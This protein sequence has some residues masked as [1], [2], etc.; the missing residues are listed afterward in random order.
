MESG[1]SLHNHFGKKDILQ[2]CNP[3]YGRIY[4]WR[5]TYKYKTVNFSRLH[6]KLH[7]KIKSWIVDYG[8]MLKGLA[9]PRELILNMI[10]FR[11]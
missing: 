10:F 5:P 7:K 1:S 4:S 11:I 8:Y 9:S 6:M 3:E 2:L